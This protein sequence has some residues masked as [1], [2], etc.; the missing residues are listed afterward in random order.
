MRLYWIDFTTAC[1]TAFTRVFRHPCML[2][3]DYRILQL[4]SEL[5]RMDSRGPFADDQF[6]K[7]RKFVEYSGEHVRELNNRMIHL[8]NCV[9]TKTRPEHG[10]DLLDI[11]RFAKMSRTQ[12]LGALGPSG[13]RP[14]S[15][16]I[17]NRPPLLCEQMRARNSSAGEPKP[18]NKW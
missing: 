13:G 3:A 4:E 9:L 2:L 10:L 7:L 11:A 1:R 14:Y 15:K 17:R 12:L 5:F 18:P 16:T 8:E 6:R